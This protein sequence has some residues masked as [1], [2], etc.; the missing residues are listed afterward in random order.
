MQALL[1]CARI[2]AAALSA[3]ADGSVCTLALARV[4]LSALCAIYQGCSLKGPLLAHC[5]L[6]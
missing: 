4:R 1:M 2:K 3:S 6:P 5:T